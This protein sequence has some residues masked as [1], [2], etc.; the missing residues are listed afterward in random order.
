MS[1]HAFG[2]NAGR[3]A[4]PLREVMGPAGRAG[5]TARGILYLLVGFLAVR[6]AMGDSGN[7]AD[8]QGA[9]RQIAAQP[10]GTAL[11]WLLAAGLAGMALW[12]A[13]TGLLVDD[14]AGKRA[15]DFGRAVFYGLVCWGTAAYAAGSGSSSGGSDQESKDWTATVLKLPGGRWLAAAAG[16]GLCVAGTVIAVRAL[17]R[18]FLK[19]METARM[20]PRVRKAVT[21]SGAVG[22]AARGAVYA[23]AGAFVVI[24]AIRFQPHQAK[25]MDE[26]LRAFAHAPAGPWLLGAVAVGLMLF[27]LF[28]LASARWRRL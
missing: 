5:F 7:K 14:K 15:A 22:G 10:F 24:A 2:R 17:R 6:I 13:A 3:A 18:T 16:L 4:R 21:V 1:T 20:G 11:L 19:K 26:T 27:G 8:R 25:G 12:R 23:G 28:S 9:L